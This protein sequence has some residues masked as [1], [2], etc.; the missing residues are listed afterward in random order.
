M[1]SAI[2]KLFSDPFISK[3]GFLKSKTDD[4]LTEAKLL[5]YSNGV[6]VVYHGYSIYEVEAID[7]IRYRVL[8]GANNVNNRFY[9]FIVAE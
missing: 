5:R 9:E 2:K 7:S 8:N 3:D 4:A 6:T 1:I